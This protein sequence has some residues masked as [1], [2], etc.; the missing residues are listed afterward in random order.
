[1]EARR[2]SCTALLLPADREEMMAEICWEFL[3]LLEE[4]GLVPWLIT[5]S[6]LCLCSGGDTR[7][8]REISL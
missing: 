6:G 3:C 2:L 1:M 8:A 4:A 5:E 7:P